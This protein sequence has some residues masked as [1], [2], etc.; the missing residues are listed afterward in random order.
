MKYLFP[1]A[2]I[3]PF[4]AFAEVSDKMPSLIEIL[5]TGVGIFIVAI[6]VSFIR[7]WLSAIFI[8]VGALYSIGL[9]SLWQDIQMRNALL[10]EQGW[11]YFAVL[12]IEQFLIYVG[13][14]GGIYFGH[15]GK[16]NKLVP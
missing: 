12:G 11:Y 14:L 1:L 5:F 16:T 15:K 7:W 8:F 2:T 10:D 4:P 3:L 9:I 6:A 13:G